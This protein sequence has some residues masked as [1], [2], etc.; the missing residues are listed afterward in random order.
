MKA[1]SISFIVLLLISIACQKDESL[2]RPT[3]FTNISI[4]E[5]LRKVESPIFSVPHARIAEG[6]EGWIAIINDAIAEEGI[7]IDK[8]EYL[9][10]EQEGRTV[11]FNDRGKKQLDSDFVPYDSRNGN[12]ALIPYFIDGTQ[13]GT[14]SGMSEHETFD[15]IVNAMNKWDALTCSEGLE[16]PPLGTSTFDIGYIQWLYG[17]GGIAGYFPGVITHGGILPG[18]FFDAI[19]PGGSSS[20]LGITFTFVY[21]DTDIDRNGKGDVAIKEIYM[22]DAFNWQDAPDDDLFNDIYDFETVVLHEVGHGLS[23]AHFGSAFVTKN[24]SIHFAP[25]ALM[26]AGYSVAKRE[27][28]QTDN[29]GHCSNWAQWPNQ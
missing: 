28:K 29:A 3:D 9:G 2:H 23:Q 8:M 12:G 13:L 15:A 16:I 19:A 21:T 7:R 1:K 5:K 14:T 17:F 20:I 27:I 6:I 18:E 26:N 10:A 4:E 24:G 25:D 11:F 22:N